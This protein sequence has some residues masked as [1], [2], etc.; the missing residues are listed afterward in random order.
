[1]REIPLTQGFCALV[2]DADYEWL[3]SFRWYF[4]SGY[5]RT[6]VGKAFVYMHRLIMGEPDG[7]VDHKNRSSLDNRRENLRL[8][9][10][11][12][13]AANRLKHLRNGTCTSLYK[14]VIRRPCGSFYTLLYHN[15]HN[16]YLGSFRDEVEAARAYDAKAKE[17]FGEFA[18][19]NFP[20]V[21]GEG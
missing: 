13:N 9:T 16:Y 5:A 2:D 21:S 8:A 15:K 11:S 18:R 10:Y 19:L 7:P 20:D 14:G 12:G 1:M 3:S 4:A 17:I 6:R